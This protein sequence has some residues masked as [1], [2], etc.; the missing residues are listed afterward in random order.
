MRSVGRRR[1]VLGLAVAFAGYLSLSVVL[2]WHVWSTH[3]AGVT[4]C[5]CGDASLFL[6][7]LE[8]P[9][10]ALAH[11]HNPFY[12]TALFHPGG[13]NLLAQTSVMG[14]SIP[15]I[16]VTW[17]WGPVAALNVASTLAPALSAFAMFM[18]L[19]RWVKWLPAAYLGGLLYGFSPS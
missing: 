9:A 8:W 16:P 11:G 6:W 5:A 18:V 2:W 10:Y 13:V 3:P 15:L 7:F 1:P 17:I 12:S 4:T 14:M 19:R